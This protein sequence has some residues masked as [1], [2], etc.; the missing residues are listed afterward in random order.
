VSEPGADEVVIAISGE[1]SSRVAVTLDVVRPSLVEEEMSSLRA[2][3]TEI[4]AGSPRH[5][6]RD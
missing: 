4:A 2:L 5:N 3:A 6:W 1:S